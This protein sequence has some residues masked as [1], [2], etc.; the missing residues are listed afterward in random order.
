MRVRGSRRTRSPG[1]PAQCH[2]ARC[3]A[4]WAGA[5]V[6]QPGEAGEEEAGQERQEP[7]LPPPPLPSRSPARLRHG[8]PPGRP[9]PASGPRLPTGHPPPPPRLWGHTGPAGL[10]GERGGAAGL[11]AEWRRAPGGPGLP[12]AGGAAVGASV[13]GIL[14]VREYWRGRDAGIRGSPAS[15]EAPR[16]RSPSSAGRVAGSSPR[17]VRRDGAA[18]VRDPVAWHL[19]CRTRR[20]RDPRPSVRCALGRALW[21]GNPLDTLKDSG[22]PGQS[23]R[24]SICCCSAW[25]RASLRTPASPRAPLRCLSQ[26]CWVTNAL[27][28][29][30]KLLFPPFLS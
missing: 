6:T 25:A 4:R 1:C 29:E 17:R 26:C 3:P 21:E 24:V 13:C 10:Q 8:P 2:G 28:F 30:Y 23:S 15:R 18:P 22:P 20:L 11:G 16:L 7:P 5:A 27:S 14:G 19:R 12:G 9:A